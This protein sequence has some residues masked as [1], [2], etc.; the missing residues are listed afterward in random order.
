MADTQTATPTVN[1]PDPAS[2]NPFASSAWDERLPEPTPAPTP[3]PTPAA[4]GE[5]TPTPAP[6]P[7]PK[8][9]DEE[10]LD[11]K[12]WL[13]REFEVDDAEVLKQR[14]KEYEALK[15]S[16]KTEAEIKFENEQSKLFYELAREGKTKELRQFLETQETLD[17]LSALDVTAETAEDII[18][19][20]LR[21]KYK[22]L[23]PREIDYKFNKEYGLP[24]EPTRSED[25]TDDEYNIRKSAWQER[26][27]DIE[28]TR[29]IDAKLAKPE[30]DKAKASLVLPELSKPAPQVSEPDPEALKEIREKFLAKLESDYSKAEGF[31]TK[32]KDESVEIPVSFKIP[33]EDKVAIKGRLQNGFEINEY[34]DKRWFDEKGGP[35]IEQI[36]SDLYQLE[37]LDKILSGVANNSANQRLVE[38]RKSVSNVAINQ[39]PQQT[40]QPTNGAQANVSPFSNEAWSEK[41][42]QFVNN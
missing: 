10:I 26:V 41:P 3:E 32:V 36:I 40:Y 14:L 42:P 2:F 25:E 7:A 4:T 34:I 5:P 20:G 13:K 31:T 24:K 15:A 28:M 17:R 8:Q 30:L 9:D 37:N 23:T 12:E 21:L 18:K 1:T 38:Y 29:I 19:T 11:P 35:K 22:D 39:T 33:D 6:E 16:P 27:N